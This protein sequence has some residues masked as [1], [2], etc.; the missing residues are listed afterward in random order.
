MEAV[1]FFDEMVV[2]VPR[3]PR[4]AGAQLSLVVDKEESGES[5]VCSK[6]K[7]RTAVLRNAFLLRHASSVAVGLTTTP[8]RGS[9]A[10]RGSPGKYG[11]DIRIVLVVVN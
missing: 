1:R 10:N 8:K 2:S 7:S 4:D 3:L 6:M 11:I 5:A 9:P